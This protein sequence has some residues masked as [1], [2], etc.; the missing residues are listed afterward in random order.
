MSVIV[1]VAERDSFVERS[2]DDVSEIV[3]LEVEC[4]RAAL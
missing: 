1:S 3:R 2:A 4:E